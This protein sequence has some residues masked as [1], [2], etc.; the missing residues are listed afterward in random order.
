MK[1][2]VFL[3]ATRADYGKIKSILK[4]IQQRHQFQLYI[5]VT[6]M[7][8]L[9]MFG[10]TYTEL[11]KDGFDTAF[12][13][14]EYKYNQRM[15]INVAGVIKNFSQYVSLIEPDMIVVHGDRQD[16]IAGAIVGAFNNILVAHIEGGE[17]SGTIDESIRH[18]ISKFAHLHFVANEEAKR[19]LV[20]LGEDEKNIFVIGSPDIDVMLT[21]S[22]PPIAAVKERYGI[23]FDSYAILLYHPVVSEVHLLNQH[24]D[25]LVKSIQESALNYVAILPNNDLGSEVICEA[26][27]RLKKSDR[28]R[29]F[30]SMRFEHFLT[31]L[32]HSQF[33]IGNSSAG[34]REACV[35]GVPAIDIG[36]RQKGRYTLETVPNI[37][38]VEHDMESIINA[39]Q[40]SRSHAINS[41]HFGSGGSAEK[42]YTALLDDEIWNI[43]V[44]KKFIDLNDY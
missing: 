36:S 38:P 11:I 2:I 21:S 14:R 28:F 6:G 17:V 9:E 10:N 34:V 13:D 31:L 4:L 43:N 23:P 22:L 12:F 29:I 20:Q 39:I 3:T 26:Y 1:K 27:S 15:D 33:I 35:Y 42:F 18:A 44:Q 8:M 37:M 16:A 41:S 19:R 7:H 30:P 5:F 24:V 40:S 32:K 25:C